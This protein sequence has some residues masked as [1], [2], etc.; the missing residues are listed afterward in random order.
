MKD[1]NSKPFECTICLDTAKEPVV[2]S[3]GHIFCWSC[4]YSWMETKGK[5][6]K[7]PNCA[8]PI[9]RETLIPIYT[10]DETKNDTKRFNIPKRPQ[11]HRNQAPPEENNNS[12]GGF[13]NFSFGSFGFF[14]F[15]GGMSF[16]F[17]SSGQ[18]MGYNNTSSNN[19]PTAFESLPPDTQKTIKNL[20]FLI[21]LIYLSLYFSF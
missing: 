15:I 16:S 11:G 18:S 12:N 6:A 8:N 14:P 10:K 17:G 4:I 7:C 20:A 3:C 5:G 19:E 9:T 21:F 2:T 13:G 1:S